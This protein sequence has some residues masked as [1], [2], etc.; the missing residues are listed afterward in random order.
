MVNSKVHFSLPC[1]KAVGRWEVDIR[2]SRFLRLEERLPHSDE[3][4]SDRRT[5][6][7]ME[8]MDLPIF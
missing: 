1:R 3:D 5:V 6:R 7:L 2:F 8:E 4:A